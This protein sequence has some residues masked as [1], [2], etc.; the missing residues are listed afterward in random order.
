SVVDLVFLAFDLGGG[1]LLLVVAVEKG[2]PV[3][4][5][6][7]PIKSGHTFIEWCVDTALSTPYDF[8][9]NLTENLILYARWEAGR[10]TISFDSNG[11]STVAAI[12]QDC[13][14]TVT[15]PAN[16]TKEGYTFKGWY[17]DVGLTTPYTFTTMPAEDLVLYAKWE[18]N[19]YTISFES[20]GG[21][22]VAAITQ[23]YGSTIT[24][25]ANPTKA[26]YT[27]VGW[28][29]AIP[30]TMPAENITLK[31]QW[32]INQYT[33]TFDSNGGSAVE[34][35]TRDYGTTV[36]APANPTK[37]GYSFKGWYSDAELTTPYTFTIIPAEDLT[38]YAKWEINQYTITFDSD[39]GSAVDP[40]TQNYNT[41]ITVPADPTKEG[42]IFVGWS[43]AIPPTM[44]A[45]NITLTAQWKANQYTITF[46]SNGGS[47]VA[48][49]TQDYGTTV[50]A[51][52]NPT[53]KGYAFKG[54][55][56]DTELTIPY[57]FTTMAAENI[58]LTARWGTVGGGSSDESGKGTTNPTETAKV[59]VEVAGNVV[60]ATTTVEATADSS[61]TTTVAVSQSQIGDAISKA[62][63]E[64]KKQAEGTVARVEIKVEGPAGAAGIVTNIPQAAVNQATEAGIDALTITTPIATVTFGAG[65]LSSLSRETTGEVVITAAR[66]EVSTLAATVRQR[67]G[68]RPVFD[69]RVTDGSGTV[70]QFAGDVT[71]S[72]PYTPKEGEDVNAIVIYYIGD[73]GEPELVS[74]CFYDPVTGRVNFS[75]GHF[76][77]YAV[78]YNK[79]NFKDVAE[80]SWYGDAVSFI[81]AR[82][83]T[84]GTGDG[85]F[86]PESKLTRGQ[87]IV[88]LMRAYGIAP[89]VDPSDNFSDA[90]LTYCTGYLAA[91]KRLGIANG[92]GNNMFAPDDAITR[93][94]MFTLL[95]NVLRTAGRLPLGT[96]VR[97]LSAFDDVL[98]IAPWA[99]EA[100]TFLTETGVINGCDGKLMP[101]NATT[102]AEMA[103]VLYNLLSR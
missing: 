66:V 6:V 47:A 64:V 25:P 8:S 21:S 18:I 42:Y 10:Y 82:E 11:G 86:S 67:V 43:T 63:E 83:I 78:G 50:V 62:T 79:I 19:Q 91:A 85:N 59:E 34:S 49:I 81:A 36:A 38:L 100:M 15:A 76:S 45:A 48:S 87:F 3:T 101:G 51:P 57:T 54:W 95:Y 13:D 33:I 20:D 40:I 68:D 46:D 27:F 1:N 24:A 41:A 56:I 80:G 75:T 32:K 14:T 77:H 4:E 23:G 72:I 69:F 93:Q 98:D 99:D 74:N 90:D 44:P 97:P 17:S 5:P 73:S 53:K 2:R 29:A 60:T 39:G 37:E 31:A 89:D 61:G 16:P 65:A 52:S 92:V 22:T 55:Y 28:S 26:G 94:E 9:A 71:V 30:T 12:T 88:M 35:I 58:T 84:W 103:Q 96:R 102:R 70:T 7:K